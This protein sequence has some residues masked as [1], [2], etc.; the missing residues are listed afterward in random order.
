[1]QRDEPSLIFCGFSN[2]VMEKKKKKKGRQRRFS[3]AAIVCVGE[4]KFLFLF[5]TAIR[6]FL[7]KLI[8]RKKNRFLIPN[9]NHFFSSYLQNLF[10]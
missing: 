3:F 8:S 2:L 4:I 1:M 10:T 9:N 5:S 6:F 7:Q